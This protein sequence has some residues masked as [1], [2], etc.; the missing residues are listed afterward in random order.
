[1]QY[2]TAPKTSFHSAKRSLQ[3]SR[4]QS[5]QP[6]SQLSR[7]FSFGTLPDQ[8]DN[9][10]DLE[11]TRS[12]NCFTVIDQSAQAP[13]GENEVSSQ[14][15]YFSKMMNGVQSQSNAFASSFF[16]SN[17]QESGSTEESSSEKV[18]GDESEFDIKAINRRKAR[19]GSCV[20]GFSV[21]Q[22]GTE[23]D[24]DKSR[25]SSSSRS[26]SKKPS[27]I[28]PPK[29][30]VSPTALVFGGNV[31]EEVIKKH[32]TDIHGGLKFMNSKISSALKGMVLSKSVSLTK[33]TN[34]FN[35]TLVLDL[36]ETL[37]T[38]KTSEN[39][40]TSK[41][42]A[43]FELRI[44]PFAEE[45]LKKMS[46]EFE[47]IIFSSAERRY[48]EV[49][50]K[51]LDPKGQHISHIFHRE[52]CIK[53]PQGLFVKDLRIIKGRELR[54]MVIVDNLVHSFSHQIDNGI[55][56]ISWYGDRSDQELKY[57]MEY[58]KEARRCPD[59]RAYNRKRLQLAD[60]AAVSLEEFLDN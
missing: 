52:H 8:E 42:T 23:E 15:N 10:S 21:S 22:P 47:I 40:N 14:P 1:M 25:S 38:T 46:K 33:K 58:L 45:F 3:G 16:G 44:R 5:P 41:N 4:T 59:M 57:L 17:G 7:Q 24:L 11:S 13:S 55:P 60:L 6:S 35:R 29:T 32:A 27:V 50:T 31:S 28:A 20:S 43:E 34:K 12:E 2:L 53:T 51:V 30:L 9:H 56:I 26:S 36:D 37:I 19:F 54:D 39:D 18:V 48:V 49:I